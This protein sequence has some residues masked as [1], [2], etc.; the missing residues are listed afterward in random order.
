MRVKGKT[1][2][3]PE[4]ALKLGQVGQIQG[5][6]FYVTVIFVMGDFRLGL[7]TTYPL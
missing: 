3:S 4:L 1:G 7:N 2:R 6:S 5:D